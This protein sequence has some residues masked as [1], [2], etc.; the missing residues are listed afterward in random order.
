MASA[1]RVPPQVLLGEATIVKTGA[2]STRISRTCGE[3]GRG[4]IVGLSNG[5]AT[6][7][8][9]RSRFVDDHSITRTP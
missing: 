2:I 6:G 7:A 8:S 9:V 3:T 5:P 4:S 1:C